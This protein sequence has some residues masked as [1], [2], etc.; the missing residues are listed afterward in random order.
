[1]PHNKVKQSGCSFGCTRRNSQW[2]LLPDTLRNRCLTKGIP[3]A[4]RPIVSELR[5]IQAMRTLKSLIALAAAALIIGQVGTAHPVA[6]QPN[7]TSLPRSLNVEPLQVLVRACGDCHSNHTN[8]P[9][10]ATFHHSPR[11]LSNTCAKAGKDWTSRNGKPIRNGKGRTNWNP[12]AHL[13]RRAG[14][15]PGSTPRCTQR[16]DSPRR[17]RTQSAAG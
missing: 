15:H 3:I 10:Y 9:W 13:S 11:G 5:N 12:S 14:C 17:I 16:R 6:S 8:W 4:P 2:L 1:M 7:I